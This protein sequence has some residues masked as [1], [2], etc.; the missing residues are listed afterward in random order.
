[1]TSRSVG[2]ADVGA[3]QPRAG[4]PDIPRSQDPEGKY[5]SSVA[6]REPQNPT[7]SEEYQ[8]RLQGVLYIG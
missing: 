2:D 3:K 1:M 7:K 6:S 5:R 8:R 4:D